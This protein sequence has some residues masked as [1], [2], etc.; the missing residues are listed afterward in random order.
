MF[1]GVLTALPDTDQYGV[2]LVV[3]LLV[4]RRKDSMGVTK[5]VVHKA[6]GVH[7]DLNGIERP[8]DEQRQVMADECVRVQAALDQRY[9]ALDKKETNQV[10]YYVKLSRRAMVIYKAAL[11]HSISRHNARAHVQQQ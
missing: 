3:S 4:E 5:E 10:M 1:Q 6:A 11:G 2:N 9:Q 7:G 8:T